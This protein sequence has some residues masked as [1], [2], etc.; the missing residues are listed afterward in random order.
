MRQQSVLAARQPA[1]GGGVS[2][3]TRSGTVVFTVRGT[4]DA[5]AGELLEEAIIASGRV[6]ESRRVIVDLSRVGTVT[7]EGRRALVLCV[8]VAAQA[9]MGLRF[10]FGHRDESH[11]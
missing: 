10:R 4:L 7:A 3:D 2:V 8:R 1:A 6:S 9:Q 5:A 11:I